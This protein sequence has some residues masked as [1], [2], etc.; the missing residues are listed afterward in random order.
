MATVYTVHL[1]GPT[2]IMI[3]ADDYVT[4]DWATRFYRDHHIV[5]VIPPGAVGSIDTTEVGE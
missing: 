3:D 2:S 1:N 4:G 5:A